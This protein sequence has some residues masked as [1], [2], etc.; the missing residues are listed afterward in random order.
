MSCNRILI[1]VCNLFNYIINKNVCV[2]IF[3]TRID[4]ILNVSVIVFKH[5]FCVVNSFLFDSSFNLFVDL[6]QIIDTYVIINFTM[7]KYICLIFKKNVFHVNVTILDSVAFCV[8]IFVFIVLMCEF[9]FNLMF[10]C[11]FN[12]F[13]WIFD[14]MT[15]FFILIE[16]FMLNLF[17]F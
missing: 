17:I 15:T 9:Q 4:V 14:L 1:F 8:I 10:I 6:G 11:N 3:N 13:I 16:I 2:F 12:I 7:I 5:L